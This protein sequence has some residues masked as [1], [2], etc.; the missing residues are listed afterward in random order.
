M[1]H[2]L[3]T[4][5]VKELEEENQTWRDVIDGLHIKIESQGKQIA[6]LRGAIVDILKYYDSPR[7]DWNPLLFQTEAEIEQ[8][9]ELVKRVRN[10]MSATRCDVDDYPLRI[11]A[12]HVKDALDALPDEVK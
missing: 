11:S 1:R 7:D 9:R 3:E 12:Q 10:M 5:K 6:A 2:D 4:D 8:V